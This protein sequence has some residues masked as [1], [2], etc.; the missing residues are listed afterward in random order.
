MS[1]AM[2]AGS[3]RRPKLRLADGL[4]RGGD[5]GRGNAVAIVLQVL[6][7]RR[8]PFDAPAATMGRTAAR[9][10]TGCAGASKAANSS[11]RSAGS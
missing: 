8:K 7:Q 9:Q 1:G 11:A 4:Q 3:R 6:Q 5:Q 2:A 10:S